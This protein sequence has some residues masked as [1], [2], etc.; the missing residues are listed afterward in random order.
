MKN[1]V[2][3][4][5]ERLQ[6]NDAKESKKN[7]KVRFDLEHAKIAV[8][9]SILSILIL[10]TMANSRLIA[11]DQEEQKSASRGIA[12]VSTGTSEVEDGLAHRLASQALSEKGT[13]GKLPSAVDRL[14]LEFFE[15]KYNVRLSNDGKITEIKLADSREPKHIDD[16][17][18]FL[19]T[20]RNVLPVAF[21]RGVKVGHTAIDGGVVE[22]FE[23]VNKVSLPVAKVEFRIDTL[24][25]LLSMS[26]E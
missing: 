3:D 22:K 26:V 6:E 25:R 5:T 19:E 17:M 16:L 20:H 10:V 2:I 18:G 21:E 11:R 8:S 13:V 1:N 23:L 4:I 7:Q 9:T 14:A 15:G 24:G 12:S